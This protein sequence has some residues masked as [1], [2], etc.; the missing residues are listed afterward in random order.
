MERAWEKE[1]EEEGA[2]RGLIC[3]MLGL[4]TKKSS[5][6]WHGHR[7]GKIVCRLCVLVCVCV[8]CTFVRVYV[9]L[10]SVCMN[11]CVFHVCV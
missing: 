8:E 4:E 11:I 2:G 5:V 10:C 9:R 6:G 3:Y 7:L 1:G